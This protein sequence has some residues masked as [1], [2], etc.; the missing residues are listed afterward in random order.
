M[1][2]DIFDNIPGNIE[3]RFNRFHKFISIDYR[4]ESISGLRNFQI[5]K[6]SILK[7]NL[8]IIFADFSSFFDDILILHG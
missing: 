6:C 5:D 8:I 1:S 4:T 2:V 3:Y 7:M